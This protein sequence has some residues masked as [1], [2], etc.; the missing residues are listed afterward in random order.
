MFKQ[1]C[2][3]QIHPIDKSMGFLCEC[4]VITAMQEN[5]LDGVDYVY[6]I[7]CKVEGQKHSGRYHPNDVAELVVE[8]VKR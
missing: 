3:T 8:N 7:S 5:E 1:F 2:W 4:F 6:Y